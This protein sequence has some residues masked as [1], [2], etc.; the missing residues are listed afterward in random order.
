M[1]RSAALA[2]CM[3]AGCVTTRG[4]FARANAEPI[5]GGVSLVL[6]G[7]AG[8]VGRSGEPTAA[9]VRGLVAGG[10]PAVMVLLGGQAA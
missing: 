4:P 9:A 5:P 1:L 2:V 6:L 3:L 8:V 7:E 10:Q